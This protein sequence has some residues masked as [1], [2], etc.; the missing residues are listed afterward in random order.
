[1]NVA[2]VLLV[3]AAGLTWLGPLPLRRV[4]GTG[5][6]PQLAVAG[7]LAAV[8]A[9]IAAWLAA[10]TVLCTVVWDSMW[11]H[12]AL[13]SCINALGL[14]GRLGLPRAMA[15]ALAVS[16]LLAGLLATAVV[17]WR[18]ARQL[19]R[20]RSRSRL[21]ASAARAVG[22]PT[23]WPG[24][25]VIPAPQPVAYCATGGP[26]SVVVVTTAALGQLDG[27]QLAAVL[28]HEYA[29]LAGR[30][31]DL[32]MVL[33]A[34]AAS[35]PRMT[36]F[37]AAA[38][39]VADLLEMCA[40]DV[41]VRRHGTTALLRALLALT[42]GP[43]AAVRATLGA[44]GTATLARAMRLASPVSR[45]TRWHDRVMVGTAVGVAVITPLAVGMA[46]HL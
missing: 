13:T 6:R 11:R 28:A 25:V 42:A 9:V 2:L 32:L 14:T 41:A 5:V 33:R 10:L 17:C 46:C 39:R 19:R 24:V 18:V 21:H 38:E 35:L 43:P 1:M 40:D 3:Y 27:P 8:G 12:Q 30:H 37:A 4:S 44:A 16:L 15:S 45:R 7:W 23:D 31:Q 20:Q 34:I 29:H 36:L 26:D 22:G